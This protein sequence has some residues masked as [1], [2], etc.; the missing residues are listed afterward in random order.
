MDALI[1]TNVFLWALVDEARLSRRA[2]SFV[3]NPDNVL[4]FSAVVGWE[5]V[6]KVQIG[7][8]TLPDAPSRFV[9][10]HVAQLG[11]RNLPI[12]LRHALA[13]E[14]LP[15]YHRDPFD[16]LLVA[17]SQTDGLPIVTADPLFNHYGVKT[18]W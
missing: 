15:V 8:L 18:I 16:R 17:Q 5:I 9:P 13:V 12:E 2:R 3:K 1:D 7:K 10:H 11:M 6:I 4:V 14:N